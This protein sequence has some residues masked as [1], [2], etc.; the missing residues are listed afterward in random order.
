MLIGGATWENWKI[1]VFWCN[2]CQMTVDFYWPTCMTCRRR[3]IVVATCILV[4]LNIILASTLPS[5]VNIIQDMVCYFWS[6]GH[7]RPRLVVLWV[8]LV[9]KYLKPLRTGCTP[10][11]LFTT[12]S[13]SPQHLLVDQVIKTHFIQTDLIESVM[14][15]IECKC[16]SI[17]CCHVVDLSTMW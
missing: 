15:V 4:C 13:V 9:Q 16:V 1:C 3:V 14:E 6:G 10:T 8:F 17:D 2:F 11:P 12:L 5:H 7:E